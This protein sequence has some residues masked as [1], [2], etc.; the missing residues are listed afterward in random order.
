MHR[1]NRR[2]VY[3]QPRERR[4][5]QRQRPHLRGVTDGAVAAQRDQREGNFVLRFQPEQPV[6]P[7][8]H[9]AAHYSGRNP[10]G[11]G[12]GQQVGQDGAAVPEAM[13]IS[14]RLILPRVAPE[15]AAAY[16]D[17]RRQCHCRLVGRGAH[18]LAPEV[19]PPQPAQGEIVD[20]KLVDA[21]LK[22]G[23]ITAHQIQVYV[24]K[25]SGAGGSPEQHLAVRGAYTLGDPRGVM[26]QPCQEL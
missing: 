14:P 10:V 8:V 1:P 23:Q 12:Y 16:E 21:R 17:D 6:H 9:E 24:V 7:V 19:A 11:R 13:P 25:R 18:Q 3:L 22:V 5:L 15:R 26:Q 4:G 2:V 20:P